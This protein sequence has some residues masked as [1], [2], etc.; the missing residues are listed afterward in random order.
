MDMTAAAA[1]DSWRDCAFLFYLP[2]QTMICLSRLFG[3]HL[4]PFIRND[5]LPVSHIQSFNS[6]HGSFQRLLRQ[7]TCFHS[8]HDVRKMISAAVRHLHIHPRGD[9]CRNTV[10]IVIACHDGCGVRLFDS[11]L[12]RRQINFMQSPLINHGIGGHTVCLLTVAGKML[13]AGMSVNE[14][15]YTLCFCNE[16]H[17]IQLFKGK[18]H[19][20]P[21]EYI[22]FSLN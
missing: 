16:S 6:F 5:I 7:T 4:A 10:D 3:N 22:T 11:I 18:Y 9:T 20:T 1:L 14:V 12:K 13:A 2:C 15:S 8:I 17:F 19:M 21:T